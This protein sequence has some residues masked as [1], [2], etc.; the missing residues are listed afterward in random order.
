MLRP[1]KTGTTICGAVYADGVVLGA[2]TRATAELVVEKNCEKIHYIA[3]NIYCCGAGTAADTEYTTAQI[4]S[5]LELLRLH[6]GRQSRVITSLTMLKRHLYQYQGHVSAALVLGGVDINGP[7]LHTV[8]PHGSVT[9]LPF[10]TM[11]S[12]SLA[13]MSV[14]ESGYEDSMSK[15]KC[16]DLV[17]RAIRAGVINDLGSGSNIDYCVIEK[18]KTELKRGCKKEAD[19][20][21]VARQ[22]VEE[23]DLQAL[24]ATVKLPKYFAQFPPG[25]TVTIGEPIVEEF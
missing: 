8:Y 23:N 21:P 10:V 15:E 20:H 7:H 12:G 14:F 13:A 4:S 5:Q 2:D 18:D 9:T 6:S 19:Q 17:T 3:P 11:G 16:I 1:K 25:T 22:T 24:K